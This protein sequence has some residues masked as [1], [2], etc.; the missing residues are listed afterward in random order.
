M[1]DDEAKPFWVPKEV[2]DYLADAFLERP[3]IH[4][5]RKRQREWEREEDRVKT[6]RDD[7]AREDLSAAVFHV[8]H[9]IIDTNEEAWKNDRLDA[10]KPK[11]MYARYLERCK[12]GGR[13]PIPFDGFYEFLKVSGRIL[14]KWLR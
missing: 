2:S 14:P 4:R 1:S 5:R 12:L 13:D 7:P 10:L 3:P 8:E 11:P 6:A 9:A